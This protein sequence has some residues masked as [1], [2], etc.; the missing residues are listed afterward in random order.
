MRRE[1]RD[2]TERAGANG[3]ARVVAD[4]RGELGDLVVDRPPF[5][6]Q[7]ADLAIGV[8]D[9]RVVAAAEGLADLGQRQLGQLAAQIHGCLLY[10]SRCV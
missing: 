5:T 7:L 9:R 3:S 6:H 4:A 10:T 1:E 8:H 2:A